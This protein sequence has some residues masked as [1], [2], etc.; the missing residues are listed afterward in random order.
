M[1]LSKF[2]QI[3]EERTNEEQTEFSSTEK[4]EEKRKEKE[5]GSAKPSQSGWVEEGERR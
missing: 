3:E 4:K 1:V 5:Q 2:S